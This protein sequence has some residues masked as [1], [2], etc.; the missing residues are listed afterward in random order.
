MELAGLKRFDDC[1]RVTPASSEA[2]S[3]VAASV[4]FY[5]QTREH[6]GKASSHCAFAGKK[7]AGLT[8][9]ATCV[10]SME[11]QRMREIIV[12]LIAFNL[13]LA[14]NRPL[15]FAGYRLSIEPSPNQ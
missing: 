14:R 8:S 5:N 10:A 13:R 4:Q 11:F 2:T 1:A 3:T 12:Q 6:N 7:R 9:N 15:K